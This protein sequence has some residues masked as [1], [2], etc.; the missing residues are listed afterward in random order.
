MVSACTHPRA[1]RRDGRLVCALCGAV[2][3]ATLAP[4]AGG[5]VAGSDAAGPW[6]W[7]RAHTALA[8]ALVVALVVRAVGGLAA[9]IV[10]M[11]GVLTHEMGHAA[12]ALIVGRPALPRFNLVCGGGL[13]HIGDRSTAMLLLYAGGAA[14]LAHQLRERPRLLA[15][16][17]GAA[18]AYA[19]VLWSDWDQVF[20]TAGGII[21]HSLFGSIFLYRALT[22]R[23]VVHGGF[24]RWLYAIIGWM[25]VA[26]AFADPWAITHDP[27]AR[28][29]Y[30]HSP[31]GVD[32]DLVVISD[33]H[34]WSLDSVAWVMVAITALVPIASL[35]L[36][37][38]RGEEK[39]PNRA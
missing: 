5:E 19:L 10:A 13:T 29:R 33:Q 32:N 20:F 3:E 11:L 30:L 35:A 27:E 24:E 28:E 6:Q 39:G 26:G 7:R 21:G 22:G 34:G 25:L 15:A 37:T 31:C 4:R 38:W 12:A 9:W 8:V 16:L 17:I 36:G 2:P 14:W 1:T 18:V 23:A